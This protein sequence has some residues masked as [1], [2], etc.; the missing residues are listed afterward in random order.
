MTTLLYWQTILTSKECKSIELDVQKTLAL[1]AEGQY[2]QVNLKKLKTATATPL[3]RA[4]INRE[5]RIIFTIVEYN[6]RPALLLLQILLDHRYERS[7]FLDDQ[8]L[9]QYLGSLSSESLLEFI[10]DSNNEELCED[11][12][13]NLETTS[14]DLRWQASFNYHQSNI[15]LDPDQ[16]QLMDA[17]L[18]AFIEGVA[19]SGKTCT[20]F[21]RMINDAQLEENTGRNFCYI[22]LS[23]RLNESLTEE[24][25][26]TV[27]P[28]LVKTST[29][30][31]I[32][33]DFLLN[34]IPDKQLVTIKHFQ[35]WLLK[36]ILVSNGIKLKDIPLE[37]MIDEARFLSGFEGDFDGRFI[38]IVE[39]EEKRIFFDIYNEYKVLLKRANL[40]NIQLSVL[41]DEHVEDR[42]FDLIM[43]DEAQAFS[44]AQLISIKKASRNNQFMMFY[45]YCQSL[46]DDLDH[47]SLLK[48]KT[49]VST[50]ITEMTFTT[51]HRCKPIISEWANKVLE[52]RSLVSGKK[53]KTIGKL[54]INASASEDPGHLVWLSQSQFSDESTLSRF[55]EANCDWAIVVSNQAQIHHVQQIFP[56]LLSIFTQEQIRGLEYKT[57]I[58]WEPLNDLRARKIIKLLTDYE[59]DPSTAVQLN[60]FSTQEVQTYRILLNKLFT[61]STRAIDSLMIVSPSSTVTALKKYLLQEESAAAQVDSISGVSHMQASLE[62]DWIEKAKSLLKLGDE[63]SVMLSKK[64]IEQYCPS[65]QWPA[66]LTAHQKIFLKKE[67]EVSTASAS[68][69]LEPPVDLREA[70]TPLASRQEEPGVSLMA[71]LIRVIDV[72]KHIPASEVARIPE[73]FFNIFLER[74]FLIECLNFRVIFQDIPDYI[75]QMTGHD[76]LNS[77]AITRNEQFK[78]CLT[79]HP[80]ASW[81]NALLMYAYH[82]EDSFIID[83]ESVFFQSKRDNAPLMTYYVQTAIKDIEKDVDNSDLIFKSPYFEDKLLRFYISSISLDQ[84]HHGIK[85]FIKS[86]AFHHFIAGVKYDHEGVRLSDSIHSF[87]SF[88]LNSQLNASSKKAAIKLAESILLNNEG[89]FE[90]AYRSLIEHLNPVPQSFQLKIIKTIDIFLLMMIAKTNHLLMSELVFNAVYFDI[91]F[92]IAHCDSLAY[93]KSK[94]DFR[95]FLFRKMRGGSLES[96][97]D[98]LKEK[99]NAFRDNSL[100]FKQLDFY[101]SLF[102]EAKSIIF[103]NGNSLEQSLLERTVNFKKSIYHIITARYSNSE[104]SFRYLFET[105]A[106]GRSFFDD[107]IQKIRDNPAYLCDGVLMHYRPQ[108]FAYSQ[109]IMGSAYYFEEECISEKAANCAIEL[110]K[111]IIENHC[112]GDK[113]VWHDFLSYK[114]S[115]DRNL[116]DLVIQ[117]QEDGLVLGSELLAIAAQE[118]LYNSFDKLLL[119]NRDAP[120]DRLFKL[121]YA[122][123]LAAKDIKISMIDTEPT[124]SMNVFLNILGQKVVCASEAGLRTVIAHSPPALIFDV[125][126]RFSTVNINFRQILKRLETIN[127]DIFA[128]HAYLIK[129]FVHFAFIS[130][131]I[132]SG[133]KQFTIDQTD[134]LLSNFYRGPYDCANKIFELYDKRKISLNPNCRTLH[135]NFM[136]FLVTRSRLTS[137]SSVSEEIL[138]ENDSNKVF[139]YI[140]LEIALSEEN[141]DVVSKLLQKE[142]SIVLDVI[143]FFEQDR[144]NN[145]SQ[146]KANIL[147]PSFTYYAEKFKKII[148]S[149]F[150]KSNYHRLHHLALN[151]H[152]YMTSLFDMMGSEIK[153][154]EIVTGI[155]QYLRRNPQGNSLAIFI[156]LYK[157]QLDELLD[158]GLIDRSDFPAHYFDEYAN[159]YSNKYEKSEIKDLFNQS[160]LEASIVSPSLRFS[161]ADASSLGAKIDN[162]KEPQM[163]K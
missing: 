61:A 36:R 40:F 150:H 12:V 41:T 43:I 77:N 161:A 87:F 114:D 102:P 2:R 132:L 147:N 92:M 49:K 24:W 157:E 5:K 122:A 155:Y 131:T 153:K 81:L 50:G 79:Q 106:L 149:E 97:V 101:L 10:N 63:H 137:G 16:Q 56:R 46:D 33:R 154:D 37:M 75:W 138:A 35:E 116:C 39:E 51:G 142:D 11:T 139:I 111:K 58:L 74:S 76:V 42:Q 146:V 9:T 158:R 13:L 65:I 72:V 67:V 66:F 126:R 62:S 115:E 107:L 129:N 141:L 160:L 117:H 128:E 44:G 103:E 15:Y 73:D 148:I 60:V 145:Y 53:K 90:A 151:L 105:N 156:S 134:I 28:E 162:L 29:S 34:F 22:T 119:L 3:Y 110:I 130:R 59:Q 80:T 19:G 48:N 18:P 112:D 30:F 125:L 26:A 152:K 143:S 68:V 27:N 88:V 94:I 20:G 8:Y 55:D 82:Q 85:S 4:K 6:Q 91:D 54:R 113:S 136:P 57:V 84:Y 108:S 83:F 86:E 71:R 78:S 159:H 123:Q 140:L 163:K 45:D 25:R 120:V 17:P 64:M 14:S 52:L 23:S 124:L 100:S 109:S 99:M 1:I 70:I 121:D 32:Y 93:L 38:C 31:F 127:L 89:L 135:D 21:A 95:S 133:V 144:I 104:K 69:S 47:I 98:F 118:E 96:I 7:A